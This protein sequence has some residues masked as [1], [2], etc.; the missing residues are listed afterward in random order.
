MTH[1]GL[2]H[3]YHLNSIWKYL[4]LCLLIISVPL[5]MSSMRAETLFVWSLL[6]PW[7]LKLCLKYSRCLKKNCGMNECAL[8]CTQ[9]LFFIRSVR[10]VEMTAIKEEV[11]THRSLE[12]GGIAGLCGGAP[13][14]IRRQKE[15]VKHG[16]KPSL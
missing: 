10:Y 2:F 4:F 13:G 9:D 6:Y 11:Y 5:D 16:H 7:H 1:P 3:S 12:T 15:R 14:S 8:R